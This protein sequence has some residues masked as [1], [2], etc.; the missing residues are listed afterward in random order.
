VQELVPDRLSW[1]FA[2]VVSRLCTMPL[3]ASTPTCAFMPKYQSLPF[4]VDDISGSRAPALFFVEDGASMMVA[5]TSVP[6]RSVMPLSAR[7][8]FT[9]AKIA[10]VRPCRSR[11]WRK[12]RMVVSSGMRSSRSSIPANRRIASL[13]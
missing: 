2:V 5:S 6:E 8:P 9:S 12:L 1:T 7:C 11:R 13:S 3:S 4:F 10:S